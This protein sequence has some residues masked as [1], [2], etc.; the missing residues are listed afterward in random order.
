MKL[1]F[2]G[3]C[4]N[5]IVVR[6]QNH[7]TINQNVTKVCT[8]KTVL[9]CLSVLRLICDVVSILP[10]PRLMTGWCTGHCREHPALRLTYV[11][12]LWE[13][14][15]EVTYCSYITPQPHDS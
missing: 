5:T 4:N 3:I 6:R 11:K 13:L 8:L 1:Q 14:S 10:F 7:S 15:A 12:V 2:N 9:K